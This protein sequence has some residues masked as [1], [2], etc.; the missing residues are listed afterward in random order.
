MSGIIRRARPDEAALLSDL[1]LRSKGHWGYDA[2]FIEACRDDLTLTAEEIAATTVYVCEADGRVVGFYQLGDEDGDAELANLFVEPAAI[3]GGVGKAL[4][5]H[6]VALARERGYPA[7]VVQ[8]DPY[9]E[10]FYRAMGME[11]VGETPSTVFAGRVL[12]QLRI[13][14]GEARV[15]E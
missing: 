14:L 9:A 3:G 13:A 1:A 5:R 11:R 2:A 8:S 6:A 10:G 15:V 7:M 12:P 4:W